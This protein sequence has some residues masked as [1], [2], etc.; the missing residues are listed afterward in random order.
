MNVQDLLKHVAAGHPNGRRMAT[1][2]LLTRIG[3]TNPYYES[4][5]ARIESLQKGDTLDELSKDIEAVVLHFSSIPQFRG[6]KTMTSRKEHI[7]N[8]LSDRSLELFTK[9]PHK[10]FS[11]V[12]AIMIKSAFLQHVSVE[13]E[14][15]FLIESDTGIWDIPDNHCA[16]PYEVL[17]SLE[18]WPLEVYNANQEA[19]GLENIGPSIWMIVHQYATAHQIF[20]MTAEPGTRLPSMVELLKAHY[21]GLKSE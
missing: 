11:H 18:V 9:G 13:L 19:E 8:I 15:R 1:Q 2:V 20:V 7:K 17:Y 4:L 6:Y 21:A 5:S 10:Q 3:A 16:E 14:R 12:A